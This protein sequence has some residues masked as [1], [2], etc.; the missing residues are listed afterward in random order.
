MKQSKFNADDSH[1]TYISEWDHRWGG[2]NCY[3]VF[4]KVFASRN[5]TSHFKAQT[6]RDDLLFTRMIEPLFSCLPSM[7]G[8]RGRFFFKSFQ[9]FTFM[10]KLILCRQ[11]FISLSQKQMLRLNKI[12]MTVSST[13]CVHM[14]HY[15]QHK[16]KVPQRGSKLVLHTA[17]SIFPKLETF[18]LLPTTRFAQQGLFSYAVTWLS[19]GAKYQLSKYWHNS[20]CL[21]WLYLK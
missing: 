3:L 20:V 17:A 13:T 9:Y 11:T 7:F 10:A 12:F 16:V 6:R 14:G 1:L 15:N 4:C 18:F 21:S 19:F 8:S 2:G 5:N